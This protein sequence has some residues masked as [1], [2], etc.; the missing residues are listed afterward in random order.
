MAEPLNWTEL[1]LPQLTPS[2]FSSSLSLHPPPSPSLPQS[3]P[4]L[5][6]IFI[7][8]WTVPNIFI[9]SLGGGSS[10]T[11]S[12]VDLKAESFSHFKP[13]LF[14][15]LFLLGMGFLWDKGNKVTITLSF[16]SLFFVRIICIT[17]RV[18]WLEER[19]NDKVAVL[20]SFQNPGPHYITASIT[21]LCSAELAS[22]TSPCSFV[23]GRILWGIGLRKV[24]D[25]C[26]N[27]CLKNSRHFKSTKSRLYSLIQIL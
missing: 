22:G 11:F 10:V 24:E 16:E 2:I 5:S 20:F 3:L 4:L 27:Y 8:T 21:K 14:P 1:I 13:F 9:C 15:R 6:L 25:K 26:E 7:I 17:L 23:G 18:T 12:P 19:A